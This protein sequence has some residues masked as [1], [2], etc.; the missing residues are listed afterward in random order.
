[1]IWAIEVQPYLG[2]YRIPATDPTSE[3]VYALCE[4]HSICPLAT[5]NCCCNWWQYAHGG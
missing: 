3:H 1:M 2:K 4:H 5:C